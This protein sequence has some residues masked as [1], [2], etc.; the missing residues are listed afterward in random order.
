MDSGLPVREANVSATVAIIIP[1]LDCLDGH[2]RSSRGVFELRDQIATRT[3][4]FARGY[5]AALVEFALGRPCGYDEESLVDALVRRAEREQFA[6]REFI[7]A[8]A[9]SE[10]FRVK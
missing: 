10:E 9:A 1:S 5:A 6:I 2:G 8:L 3:P 7:H 4:A